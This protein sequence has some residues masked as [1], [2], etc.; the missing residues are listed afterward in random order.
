[1]GRTEF[2]EMAIDNNSSLLSISY[3]NGSGTG[4]SI[5]RKI[6]IYVN[7]SEPFLMADILSGGYTANPWEDPIV[8]TAEIKE[9]SVYKDKL[10]ISYFYGIE[11]QD[12]NE[13]EYSITMINNIPEQDEC[14]FILNAIHGDLS[15]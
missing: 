9:L 14:G 12:Q 10:I 6:I 13:Y 5:Y 3:S 15:D 7:N 2:N 1:M 8:H 11:N 4:I